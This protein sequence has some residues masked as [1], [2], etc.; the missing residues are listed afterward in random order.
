MR[1]KG[2]SFNPVKDVKCDA[3]VGD[4]DDGPDLKVMKAGK[5]TDQE[6]DR[7]YDANVKRPRGGGVEPFH[8]YVV[9]LRSVS[10]LHG[11]RERGIE[12]SI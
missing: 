10:S 8:A 11:E 4:V 7:G 1:R 6:T 12:G 9:G 2:V 3:C 5:K